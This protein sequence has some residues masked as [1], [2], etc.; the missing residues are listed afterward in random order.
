MQ[1]RIQS[2]YHR[3]GANRTSFNPV[4]LK[5]GRNRP[6]VGDFEEERGEKN[7]RGDWGEKQHKQGENAQPVIDQ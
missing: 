6:T 1:S 5:S 3:F 4:V 7:K 2:S